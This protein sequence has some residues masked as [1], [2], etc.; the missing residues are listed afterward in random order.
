M[1][2]QQF[3]NLKKG[4][5]VRLKTEKQLIDEGWTSIT[6]SYGKELVIFN[7]DWFEYSIVEPMIEYLGQKVR[8]AEDAEDMGDGV[9]DVWLEDFNG[10]RLHGSWTPGMIECCI[11]MIEA[12]RFSGYMDNVNEALLTTDV[13]T[14]ESKQEWMAGFIAGYQ[15]ALEHMKGG[16]E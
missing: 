5:V 15:M 14:P 4:M 12:P 1:D 2:R 3:K 8:V 16:K 6:Q 7:N 11:D 9:M 13:V 10:N